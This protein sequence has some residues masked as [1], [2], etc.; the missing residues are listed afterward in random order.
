MRPRRAVLQQAEHI[1]SDTRAAEYGDV[2]DNFQRIAD[3]WR[4]AF[5]WELD[6]EDVA[7][8]MVLVKIAR[9]RTN[10]LHHDSWVDIAGYAALGAEVAG[11][12]SDWEDS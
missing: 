2:T 7:L 12:L 5:G 1:V 9:L 4:A 10:P 8:A 11:A 3:L 6:A